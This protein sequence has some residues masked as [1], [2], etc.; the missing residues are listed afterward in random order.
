[1]SK[2]KKGGIANSIFPPRYDFHQMLRNQARETVNGVRAMVEWMENGGRSD[3]YHL[4]E[5]EEH[6]DHLRHEMQDIL[7]KAFST[8]FDRQDI[9]SISRQMDYVLNYSVSTAREMWAFGI[10]P[11]QG[12]LDMARDL[13][14]G[15]EAMADSVEMMEHDREGAEGLIP[16]GRDCERKIE[17][18]YI[19]CMRR[20]FQSEDPMQAMKEREIYHHLKDAGGSLSVTLDILHRIIVGIS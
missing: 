6:A 5:I 19:E 13:L 8:P 4:M 9:Y 11:H 14:C 2:E 1:M 16:K 17:N 3:P 20:V 15:T 18:T 10:A 12:M 7:M